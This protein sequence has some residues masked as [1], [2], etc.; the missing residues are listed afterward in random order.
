M[1]IRKSYYKTIGKHIIVWTLAFALF[2]FLR[3]Y[4]QE[5]VRDVKEVD[6]FDL[7]KRIIFQTLLGLVS[8]FLFGTYAY[9]FHR[10]KFPKIS[11]GKVI[12]IGA[13]GYS[14]VIFLFII[15]AFWFFAN[16]FKA[17]IDPEV[18][19]NY[20][21]SGQAWVLITFCFL[22]GFLIEFVEEIDKKFGP[23]NLLKM[24]SGKFYRPKQEERVFMFLDMRSSTTA[25][26][27]LGHIRYSKLIQ[28]CFKD[29]SVVIAHN[30]QIYQY[31]GDEA[32]LTWSKKSKNFRY[33]DC[34][35]AYYAF[36][37]RLEDRKEHYCKKY[38]LLPEFKAGVHSGIVT[39]AEVGEIKREIAYHGDTINM[40]A[41]IQAQCNS[42][43]ENLLVSEDVVKNLDSEQDWDI[44]EKGIVMLKGKTNKVKIYSIN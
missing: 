24:L 1:K 5:I 21:I 18:V 9:W 11:F 44:E 4:G 3:E 31:V 19:K 39:V 41:R 23:G 32:V 2:N 34:I 27:W 40:A 15:I 43:K 25:A 10:F 6:D 26:E 30:A 42:Y 37:K 33:E 29:I 36:A 14:L 38:G 22:I 20:F 17:D 7:T 12:F 8:G 16:V 13:L 28:D 35:D